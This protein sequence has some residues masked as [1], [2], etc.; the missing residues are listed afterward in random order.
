MDVR[1]MT[2]LLVVGGIASVH[3]IARRLGAELTLVKTDAAQT[4]RTARGICADRRRLST[5]DRV[6]Q[7]DEVTEALAE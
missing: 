2:H 1:I 4:M 5:H 7:A 3:D 6:A